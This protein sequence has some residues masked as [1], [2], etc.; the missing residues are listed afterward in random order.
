MELDIRSATVISPRFW[1]Y[2]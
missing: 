2:G 1:I